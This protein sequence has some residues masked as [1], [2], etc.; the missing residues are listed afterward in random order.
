MST[1]NEQQAPVADNVDQNLDDDIPEDDPEVG[2]YPPMATGNSC[3]KNWD[4]ALLQN[5]TGDRMK[6]IAASLDVAVATRVR[7]YILYRAIFNAMST[8][9]SCPS[10]PG[11]DCDPTSHMFM[12]TEQPPAGWVMGENNIFVEPTPPPPLGG[13]S[14]APVNPTLA[15]PVNVTAGQRPQLHTTQTLSSGQQHLLLNQGAGTSQQQHLASSLANLGVRMTSSVRGPTPNSSLHRPTGSFD[16]PI[17]AGQQPL[18]QGISQPRPTTPNVAQS[19]IQGAAA[20]TFHTLSNSGN[21]SI[22][23]TPE[24]VALRAQLEAEDQRI[25]LQQQQEYLTLQ[26]QAQMTNEQA[27]MNLRQQ[28]EQARQQRLIEHQQR[29]QLLQPAVPASQ[30]TP[31]QTT[32]QAIPTGNPL[33]ASPHTAFVGSP[34][35]AAPGQFA[36][37][38]P[39]SQPAHYASTGSIPNPTPAVTV[40]PASPVVGMTHEQI[41]ALIDQRTAAQFNQQMHAH[42]HLTPTNL[43]S[44]TLSGS[45]PQLCGDKGKPIAHSIENS[46]QAAR[47]GIHVSPVFELQG[48]LVS[49]DMTK[50]RKIM[51]PGADQIGAGLVF[52]QIRWPHKMLQPGVPGFDV[53]AHKDLTFH[54]FIN[55]MLSKILAETP[56]AKLDVELANKMMFTQFLVE[57]SFHYTHKQVLDTCHEMM[58]S[59][60]MK[61]F[62]WSNWP[63]IESRLKNIKSRYTQAPQYHT[64][65]NRHPK[66]NPG[67]QPGG[68]QGKQLGKTDING[69][70]KDYMRNNQICMNFNDAGCKEQDSHE[71]HFKKGQTL[72]HICAGC[73]KKFNKSEEKHPVTGCEKGPFKALF[74]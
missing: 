67:N 3:T 64:F 50:M 54:Q 53:T 55:G 27:M 28:H 69:V 56:A 60:M 39:I 74:R 43:A 15:Q 62:E 40:Q 52:R 12:P 48:D 38:A 11:G 9:Q 8:D 5:C 70:P 49:M 20:S 58:M 18:I 34:N 37:P 47:L 32:P 36:T 46:E 7:K 19:V 61:E 16:R 42:N 45:A 23:E 17:T 44:C 24:I 22:P 25:A 6:V 33:S 59:W 66:P 29:C 30:V 13:S 73:H 63:L 57:M 71:N 2:N 41:L 51:T 1:L 14:G 4:A 31:L 65:Q 10:C 21:L 72:K 68:Q 26:Q 35:L